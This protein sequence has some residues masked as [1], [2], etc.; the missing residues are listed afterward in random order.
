MRVRGGCAAPPAIVCDQAIGQ[1]R[2]RICSRD[3]A[4]QPS[5]E[6]I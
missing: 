5:R 2:C 6:S 3:G 1:L 4:L